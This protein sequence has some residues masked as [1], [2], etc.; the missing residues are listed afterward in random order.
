MTRF[1]TGRSW[2]RQ[3]DAGPV[4]NDEN[5]SPGEDGGA[6]AR[7]G[8]GVTGARVGL[9]RIGL[10]DLHLRASERRLMLGVVDVGLLC[11][12]LAVAVKLR[13]EWLDASGALLANWKWFATLA[14]LWL[15]AANLLES[16]DLAR[17]ASAPHSMLNVI[18]TAAVTV[19][20]YQ[21]IPVLSPPLAS[22]KLTLLFGLLAI[23]GVALWRGAYAV[24]FVQPS[25]HQR[26]LVV[27]AG[28]AGRALAEALQ[29]VPAAGNP[30]HGTGYEIAGFVDDDPAKQAN[31]P[32]AGLRVLG[33][34]GELVQLARV[35]AVD[36]VILAITQRDTICAEAY[37]A[38]MT[39]REQGI[40]V[41]T[42]PALYERLLGRV[43]VQ[44]VGGDFG[45]VLPT[46]GGAGARI[47]FSAKRLIDLLLGTAG[48]AVLGVA[49]PLVW[50]ANAIWAPG[51][52]LYRQERVGRRGRHFRVVKFRTMRP[53]AERETGAVWS[54]E[55][56]RRI[57]PVGRWLRRSRLDELPQ[58]VNVVRGEMS[59][60]GP[61]PE[62]P[63]FVAE[64]AAQIP[65]YRARHAVRPGITGWAQVRFG[66]GNSLEGA[67][68]KLEYDLYYVR[69]ANFY[70]DALIL[71]KTTAV[72]LRLQG[73]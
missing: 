12:A 38:L 44:H 29:K 24:L 70:L 48:L 68:T 39:C 41:T 21:W 22:R 11:A 56:D 49:I 19:L 55:N 6:T 2:L 58:L 66:Y 47:Y 27:G 42:M 28:W 32:V 40:A 14:V 5:G 20:I 36:E 61:R 31:G 72:V 71:L 43:P 65:F 46:E 60:I 35:Y 13:T 73:Q 59:L 3:P 37:E 34:C 26:A 69:H 1:F 4:Q 7:A 51:P 50:L 67:R 63:E 54:D 52:L 18:G 57:T 9:R 64:L 53:D 45:A 30:F 17:A 15:C 8:I 62:R 23:G 16:Y 33:G 25:F 10:P